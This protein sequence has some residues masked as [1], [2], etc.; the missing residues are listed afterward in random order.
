MI[1]KKNIS[2]F[3]KKTGYKFKNKNLLINSLTHPSFI[4]DKKNN[5]KS[6]NE[7]FERLEFLG[8]R[9]LGLAIA[10]LIYNKFNKKNEGDLSKKLS[11]F[12]QKNFLYKI[13]T[14]LSIDKLLMHTFKKKNQRMNVSI[15]ADAVESIIGAVYI[16]GG[17]SNSIIFINK[18]WGPYLDIEESNFQDPKT[19]LQE[20]S[21]QKYKKLPDYILLKKEGP[22][23][24][25]T[26]TV[27][28][29]A[30]NLKRIKASGSSIREAEKNAANIAIKL[31]ND[32]KN[33]KT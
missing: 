5:S 22:S 29:K 21:Q 3:E 30:L 4:L 33:S 9:V 7:D 17:F 15:L 2:L 13:A 11:Y 32:K 18:I 23:H 12:V 1:S 27:S 8:D 6:I 25:P 14:E 20:I 10:S 19:Q 31:I 24:S 26:F 28:L 16:D